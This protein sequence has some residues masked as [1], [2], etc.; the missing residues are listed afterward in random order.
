M[1]RSDLPVKGIKVIDASTVLA[2]PSVGM[3]FA[4]LGAEVIKVEHPKHRDVTRSWK[5]PSEAKDASVSAYFSSVNFGKDYVTLDL[6]D[7]TDRSVFSELLAEAD[8]LLMNFKR[9]DYEKFG[10]TDDHLTSQYPE[11]I[12]GKISGYGTE[13]DRVAYDLIIQAESGFMS[14]NGQANGPP[15]KMPVAFVDVLAA[16]HLKEAILLA[17][18]S[19]EKT[20]SGVVINVSLHDAAVSSLVNQASNY[21]MAGH[22]PQRIGS[23]HPN[24]APYGELFTTED[25]KTIT[26]AIGS[27]SHFAKLCE[28]LKVSDLSSDSRFESNQKRVENRQ[29]LF[30]LLKVEVSRS[31][32]EDLL[33]Q[34]QDLNVPA[35]AVKNL[36]EVFSGDQAQSLILEETIDGTITR[37]VASAI[38]T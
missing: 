8:I 28:T 26:F 15:T 4:E 30:D 21:L 29:E 14:M 19:R 33:Q 18:Y 7:T 5:L 16:H 1:K 13:S 17:L 22:I 12:V 37:R 38:F 27:D 10:L 20:N 23:K 35:G 34:L 9:S 24:I 11:L 36:E 3:Y 31:N 6:K 2:G 32:S 25:D